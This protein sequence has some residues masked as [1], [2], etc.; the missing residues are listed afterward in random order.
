M[1]NLRAYK[2][3]I[4]RMKQMLTPGSSHLEFVSQVPVLRNLFS[5]DCCIMLGVTSN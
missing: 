5:T 4:C 2:S 1:F 3:F